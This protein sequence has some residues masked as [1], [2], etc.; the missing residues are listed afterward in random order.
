LTPKDIEKRKQA[1]SVNV[2]EKN[3]LQNLY[4]ESLARKVPNTAAAVVAENNEKVSFF[5]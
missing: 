5:P 1:L 3:K 4:N 2:E